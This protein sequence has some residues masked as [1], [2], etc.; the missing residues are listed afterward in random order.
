MGCL[1]RLRWVRRKHMVAGG[2]HNWLSIGI[3]MDMCA[4][5][6]QQIDIWAF[7][8]DKYQWLSMASTEYYGCRHGYRR[9]GTCL[10][11]TIMV[12]K[13]FVSEKAAA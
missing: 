9:M 12:G 6:P 11:F 7:Q 1:D 10:W 5:M 4:Y 3:Y 2:T 13:Y 8:H